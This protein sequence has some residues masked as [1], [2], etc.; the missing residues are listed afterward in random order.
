MPRAPIRIIAAG[1]ITALALAACG[2]EAPRSQRDSTSAPTL[3]PALADALADPILVDPDLGQQANGDALRPPDRPPSGG[4]PPVDIAP[5]APPA[6][7]SVHAPEPGGD[8]AE[9]TIARQARTLGALAAAGRDPRTRVCAATLRYS[10]RWAARMPAALP[11]PRDARVLVAAGT[12]EGQC[13]LRA[14]R[15]VTAMPVKGAI[16]FYY[17]HASASGFSAEHRADDD[18]NTLHGTRD[19]DAAAYAVIVRP[20]AQ[21]GSVIDLVVNAAD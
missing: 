17:A 15:F 11:L 3:D 21:G 13:A 6:A 20:R 1:T 12:D 7:P 16:D 4:L 14:A 9:C 19:R 2:S 5:I 18:M 10:A 8:C